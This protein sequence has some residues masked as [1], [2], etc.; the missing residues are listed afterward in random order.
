MLNKIIKILTPIILIVIIIVIGFKAYKNTLDTKNNPLSIIPTNSSLILQ[1]NNLNQTTKNLNKYDIWDEVSSINIFENFEVKINNLNSIFQENVN[2]FNSNC[3]H[4]S[5]CKTGSNHSDFL[6]V[7]NFSNKEN[8]DLETIVSLFGNVN[9]FNTYDNKKIFHINNNEKI[10]YIAFY[11]DILFFSPSKLLIENTIKQ[12]PSNESLLNVP[13][14]SNTYNTINKSANINL[15]INYNSILDLSKIYFKNLN[16][17]PNFS[18]W[19][20]TDIK[21]KNNAIIS[22]GFSSINKLNKNFTDIFN[23][24]NPE[25]I[26]I[27]NLIP[28]T[29]SFLL[30]LGYNKNKIL[31]E[32]RKQYLEEHNNFWSWNKKIKQISDSSGVNYF[33]LFSQLEHEAGSF[34]ISVNS[35]INNNFTYI[36]NK[37]ALKTIGI[38]QNLILNK[39][40]YLGMTIN[41]CKDPY[42]TKTLFS[43]KLNFK[44]PYFTIIEDFFIFS[45]SKA[46]IKYIIENYK[47]GNT[48]S[49]SKHFNR[50]NN[51][52]SSKSNFLLYLNLG[53][54]LPELKNNLIHRYKS[55]LIFNEDS[56]RNLTAF[57]IQMSVAK[58]LLLNNINIFY[59]DKFQ[60][61]LKEEW[62]VQ[63][64]S[65]IATTPYFVNN[66]FTKQKMIIVQTQSN[67]VYA[68]DNEGKVIWNKLI[69][70]KIIGK[71]NSIDVYN[72]NK[73]QCLFNTQDQIHIIDRN[74]NYV[75]GFPMNLPT[76]T[77]LG[78]SLLDYNNKK[79]Y[80]IMIVGENNQIYNFNAKGKKVIG[81]KYSKNNDVIIN[82]IRHFKVNTKDYLLKET[83]SSNSTLLAINGAKRVEYRHGSF[84]NKNGIKIDAENG[85]LYAITNEGKIWKA[86]LSGNYTETLIQ[87]LNQNSRIEINNSDNSKIII[88]NSKDIYFFNDSLEKVS[89]ISFSDT[90]IDFKLNKNYMLVTSND[91]LSLFKNETLLKG[92]PITTDGKF[93]IA[94]IDNDNSI[95]IINIKNN[96]VYNYELID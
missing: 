71:I 65:S 91:E 17:P 28:K 23:G 36:K 7:T 94:D 83:N 72:N 93:N 25:K 21:F 80:R 29:T 62:F 46:G 42:L 55:E 39:S 90:I 63:L 32:N 5:L 59:D 76:K 13:S 61:N 87:E 68:L 4:I 78:H 10:E 19:V 81:W 89:T 64:D 24:Q 56:I 57:S 69:D 74:G 50:S 35:N 31:F 79:R 11:K 70:S 1:L 51:Y 34:S 9:G 2:V 67:R 18:E 47:A 60:E 3:M 88:A 85:E 12:I 33:E 48:L 66:H 6:Y 96:S 82:S 44:S 45:G 40:K 38:I 58:N 92:F 73:Y 49:K 54:L 26:E 86:N 41:E 37:N 16:I 30:C 75:D 8:K 84:F 20:S 77:L 52:L 22:S 15:Y 95:N 53:R 27:I 43:D 14:F